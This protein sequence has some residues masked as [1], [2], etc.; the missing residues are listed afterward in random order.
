LLSEYL[1][2]PNN[3]S[4]YSRLQILQKHGHI[5]A[6]YAKSYKLAGREA[7]FYLLPKGLRALR[8]AN[9][10]EVSDNM[11]TALYKDRTVGPEFLTQQLQL[12][13]IRN[14]LVRTYDDLQVF[15]RRDIHALE[16]FPLPRPDLFMSMKNGEK[17]TRFFVEYVPASTLNNKLRKR[18]EYLTRYYE[19]DSWGETDT[20]FPCILFITE[21][22]IIE[23]GLKRLISR[24]LYRSDTDIACY[25]T[26]Q[27][28]VLGLT[29]DNDAIWTDIT[30]PD[31]LLS[32]ED[33]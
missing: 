30:Q 31:E 29:P 6:H 28:A 3:T 20:L 7:E 1:G 24:E 14:K 10:L 33:I 27:K 19:Q 22:G 2:V 16:Y 32:L 23:A 5:A 25:T 18:L 26:T 21:T 4:F 8:D 15:T 9:L 13:R 17:I 12:M 11:L